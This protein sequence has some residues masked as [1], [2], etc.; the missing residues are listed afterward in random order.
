[1]RSQRHCG[2]LPNWVSKVRRWAIFTSCADLL[3]NELNG[4]R[5]KPL[6]NF[7]MSQ[8]QGRMRRKATAVTDDLD[9][10]MHGD[11]PQAA[12]T[13]IQGRS[14]FSNLPS[15]VL[16]KISSSRLVASTTKA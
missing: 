4:D 10:Y 14:I 9:S 1:V 16:T 8:I 3:S 13:F 11:E 12:E 15:L 6:T 7:A 5:D 2:R